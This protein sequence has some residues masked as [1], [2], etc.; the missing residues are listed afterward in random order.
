MNELKEGTEISHIVGGIPNED[1]LPVMWMI[2]GQGST[3][4]TRITVSMQSGQMSGI[5]WARCELESGLV[6]MVNLATV[7]SVTLAGGQS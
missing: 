3:S 2:G 4:C 5:P 7:E 1:G 6:E